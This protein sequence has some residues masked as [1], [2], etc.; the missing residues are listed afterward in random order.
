VGVWQ[1][2]RFAGFCS[3]AVGFFSCLWQKSDL[4]RRKD[5]FIFG[6]LH[7]GIYQTSY[8]QCDLQR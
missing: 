8:L 5:N 7:K 2:M 4:S 1:N 3:Q 6:L